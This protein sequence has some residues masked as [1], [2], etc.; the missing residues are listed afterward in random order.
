MLTLNKL[1]KL[2]SYLKKYYFNL[3]QRLIL[4]ICLNGGIYILS[5]CNGAGTPQQVQANNTDNMGSTIKTASN[6]NNLWNSSFIIQSFQGGAYL[7]FPH[8]EKTYAQQFGV[9][10]PDQQSLTPALQPNTFSP[11]LSDGEQIIKVKPCYYHRKVVTQDISTVDDKQWFNIALTNKN[12]LYYNHSQQHGKQFAWHELTTSWEDRQDIKFNSLACYITSGYETSGVETLGDDLDVFDA[13]VV[14]VGGIQQGK[15]NKGYF[16]NG[17]LQ[18]KKSDF[19]S[20]A[21]IPTFGWRLA[22]Q[23]SSKNYD[24]TIRDVAIGCESMAGAAKFEALA[25]GQNGEMIRFLLSYKNSSPQ[26]RLFSTRQLT[27]EEIDTGYFNLNA[28]AYSTSTQRFIFAGNRIM[29]T[30]EPGSQKYSPVIPVMSA[31]NISKDKTIEDNYEKYGPI[32]VTSIGCIRSTCLLA[33]KI[34]NAVDPN[35][36]ETKIL[37]VNLNQTITQHFQEIQLNSDYNLEA[38]SH[39]GY[40]TPQIYTD[41]GLERFYVLTSSATKA[42]AQSTVYMAKNAETIQLR[43]FIPIMPTLSR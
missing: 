34:E 36:Y 15:T 27:D 7:V 43:P 33:I 9:N 3:I 32:G 42:T 16:A 2:Y 5:A 17:Y 21:Y 31:L 41:N 14:V 29:G 37:K 8:G 1:T 13:Y 38:T 22:T 20:S 11:A 30:S 18:F 19:S 28:V 39:L 23:V 10:F 25:V 6:F 12:H 24:T 40:L 4:I 35:Q 26:Y